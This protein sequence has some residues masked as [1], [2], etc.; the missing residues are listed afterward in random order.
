MIH[1][2]LQNSLDFPDVASIA[3]PKPMMFLCGK[4]DKLFPLAAI[5]EAYAKMR[6]VWE[7]RQ[8][9]EKLETRIYDVPHLFNQSMQEDAFDWLDRQLKNIPGRNNDS[10]K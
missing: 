5:N 1:A 7:S 3:C 6:A 9:G 8:A 4:Q 2:G 10:Q